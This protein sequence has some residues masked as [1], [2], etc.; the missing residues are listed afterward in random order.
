MGGVGVGVREVGERAVKGE[1]ETAGR[2]S[3]RQPIARG[4]RGVAAAK[5]G[6][7]KKGVGSAFDALMGA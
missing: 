2:R 6:K 1:A 7:G 5:A 4:A 3:R